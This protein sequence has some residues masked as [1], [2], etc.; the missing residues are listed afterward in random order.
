MMSTRY[1]SS[2][3]W[4]VAVAFLAALPWFLPVHLQ[5]KLAPSTEE[6]RATVALLIAGSAVWAWLFLRRESQ[7]V[8]ALQSLALVLAFAGAVA[9]STQITRAPGYPALEDDYF[10]YRWDAQVG[11]SGDRP[12]A[13]APEIPNPNPIQRFGPE[14]ETLRLQVT[15]PGFR[16]PYPP[17]AQLIFRGTERVNQALAGEASTP[18]FLAILGLG[19]AVAL[20][21]ALAF[22]WRVGVLRSL[23]SVP[24]ILLHPL[25]QYEWLHTGHFDGWM[26]A[27]MIVGLTLFTLAKRRGVTEKGGTDPRFVL[28]F[29]GLA[30]GTASLVKW[31]AA[32][33]LPLLWVGGLGFSGLVLVTAGFIS[34][35]FVWAIGT[36][37]PGTD[38]VLLL[39]ALQEF[40]RDWEMNSGLLRGIRNLL[41]LAYTHGLPLTDEQLHWV[42][43]F[44]VTTLFGMFFAITLWRL[45]RGLRSLES[46][47]VLTLWMAVLLSPI[48]NPWYF[49][50]SIPFLGLTPPSRRLGVR[51]LVALSCIV[52]PLSLLFW[53]PALQEGQRFI[54]FWDFEHSV[55]WFLV[56]V[57]TAWGV[58]RND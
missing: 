52:L 58:E 46:A 31:T 6:V 40:A 20:C 55:L 4:G 27:A 30:L 13:L 19:S 1:Q 17:G 54:P 2:F 25:I 18:R 12:H 42:P 9:G 41:A 39:T 53:D 28:C 34:P 23:A 26:V 56:V 15:Y 44:A 21:V 5:P 37:A 24:L 8:T 22:A 11:L 7:S 33:L 50:W 51:P 14:S 45:S 35:W 36:G 49:A 32:I 47:V 29:C 16:T 48:S 43:R 3:F 38:P 10:R 57:C